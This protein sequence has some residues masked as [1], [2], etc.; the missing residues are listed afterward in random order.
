VKVSKTNPE[1]RRIDV[2]AEG[3]LSRMSWIAIV[4]LP[5]LCAVLGIA[6]VWRRNRR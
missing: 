2:K 5:L 6:T 4:A 1:A 3:N